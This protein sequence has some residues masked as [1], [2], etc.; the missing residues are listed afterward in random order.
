MYFVQYL[1]FVSEQKF[2]NCPRVSGFRFG[3]NLCALLN[4]WLILMVFLRFT[5][6][7]LIMLVARDNRSHLFEREDFDAAGDLRRFC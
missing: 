6:F 3:D 2:Q 4:I 1:S 7:I 5:L